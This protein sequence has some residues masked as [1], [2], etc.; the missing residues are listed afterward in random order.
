MLVDT[1]EREATRHAVGAGLE[2]TLLVARKQA[3]RDRVV[4]QAAR[5]EDR[6]RKQEAWDRHKGYKR[7]QG[8]PGA[9]PI[10][11]PQIPSKFSTN[12]VAVLGR[13]RSWVLGE[14][15]HGAE[16]PAQHGA[17]GISL[18][19]QRNINTAAVH[20]G[21]SLSAPPPI[22]LHRSETLAGL[23]ASRPPSPRPPGPSPAPAGRP[24]TP[25]PAR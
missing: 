13:G 25:C 16:A 8:F 15:V 2:R 3:E 22:T 7:R 20:T 14:D 9:P 1:W 17:L 23:T 24:G 18:F 19:A 4:K 6:K 11:L 12:G 21:T 10:C 5:K